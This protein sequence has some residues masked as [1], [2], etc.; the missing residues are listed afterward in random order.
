[1]SFITRVTISASVHVL[2]CIWF[3]PEDGLDMFLRNV[4][5]SPKY[6]A[7]QLTRFYSYYRYVLRNEMP[8][9]GPDKT[10][11]CIKLYNISLR[12]Y[13]ILILITSLNNILF[14]CSVGIFFIRVLTHMAMAIWLYMAIG[15]FSA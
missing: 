10:I 3:D 7:L 15:I 8:F 6:M 11:G 12:C 13:M 4:E 1:M 5:L 9:S 14:F 2:I